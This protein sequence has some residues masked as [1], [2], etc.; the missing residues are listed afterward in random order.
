VNH[1]SY[2]TPF[3]VWEIPFINRE[4]IPKSREHLKENIYQFDPW[5]FWKYRPNASPQ[6][7][8]LGFRN[9]E[10]SVNKSKFRIMAMGDSCT[11][12]YQLPWEKTYSAFLEQSLNGVLAD[13]PYEVINAGVPG[14]SSFQ[15]LRYFREI[16]EKYHPDLI[17]VY[18]GA[19]DRAEARF[20][21]KELSRGKL[22]ALTFL[23]WAEDH[24]R[25]VQFLMSHC[26]YF[27]KP[28]WT[29]RVTPEDYTKNLEMF[30]QEARAKN[31][32]L[33]FIKSCLRKEIEK[34][35][36]N[37]AYVPP[38]P[39]VNMFEVFLRTGKDSPGKIYFDEIHF[40]ELGHQLIAEAI[41]EKLLLLGVGGPA[42]SSEDPITPSTL[43]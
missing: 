20:V 39:F 35:S 14:Y 8:S 6:I 18:F 42:S 37:N 19:N 22:M 7:N 33:I 24:A 26:D 3:F 25:T 31:I 28:Q 13:G 40:T 17:V 34:A 21:D 2:H 10:F 16:A 43:T 23:R 41:H 38:Q 4:N 27:S 12:G 1:F 11:A 5:L 9:G 15:G 29:I 32:K 30:A 36:E